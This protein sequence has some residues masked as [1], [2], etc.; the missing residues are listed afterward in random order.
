MYII[1]N[2]AYACFLL[3]FPI[4]FFSICECLRWSCVYQSFQFIIEV[5]SVWSRENNMNNIL[6]GIWC[7]FCN[8]TNKTTDIV[9]KVKYLF[10]S[11]DKIPLEGS[12]GL[13]WMVEECPRVTNSTNWTRKIFPTQI[14][15][16]L[17][18]WSNWQKKRHYYFCY[19]NYHKKYVPLFYV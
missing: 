13:G 3:M 1:E 19:H 8:D 7:F 4:G 2:A 18:N 6:Y 10:V 17:R 16:S 9:P 15:K 11:L 14:C 12:A 5:N